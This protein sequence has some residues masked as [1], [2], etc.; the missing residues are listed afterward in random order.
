[1][2]NLGIKNLPN[3]CK[4]LAMPR[5]IS[6]LP[7][8]SAAKF[9]GE[10][11]ACLMKGAPA[12]KV[13]T[14]RSEAAFALQHERRFGETNEAD[15]K[16]RR[17]PEA[18]TRNIEAAALA[19]PQY[20]PL[21]ER[22]ISV[23]LERKQTKPK[24][25]EATDLVSKLNLARPA[26]PR[27]IE[28]RDP[29]LTELAS[30]G[31]EAGLA[32][33]ATKQPA[34][35]Q[36]E[37]ANSGAE[38]HS[39]R[40]S[41]PHESAVSSSGLTKSALQPRKDARILP[42]MRP[43]AE[44]AK[45]PVEV[46]TV[47]RKQ[48][49]STSQP[50]HLAALPTASPLNTVAKQDVP[51]ITPKTPLLARNVSASEIEKPDGNDTR[52]RL[53]G[54]SR[55]SEHEIRSSRS[56]A[57]ASRDEAQA[58]IQIPSR[59][60][61]TPLESLR[62]QRFD[63][64]VPRRETIPIQTP[65]VRAGRSERQGDAIRAQN[66]PP[67]R[68]VQDA[69]NA[70][71]MTDQRTLGKATVSG[72]LQQ[73]GTSS[74]ILS[75][76]RE[77]AIPLLS[78]QDDLVRTR[79]SA[80][81]AG[82]ADL[83]SRAGSQVRGTKGQL[84]V[85]IPR[86]GTRSHEVPVSKSKSDSEEAPIQTYTQTR[87][88]RKTNVSDFAERKL[89][90]HV[91]AKTSS[92]ATSSPAIRTL[93]GDRPA[94]FESPRGQ[95]IEARATEEAKRQ[96]ETALHRINSNSKSLGKYA[97]RLLKDVA[98]GGSETKLQETPVMP[99]Q[100]ISRAM[101]T[102]EVLNNEK[103]KALRPQN[104]RSTH[105][106]RNAASKEAVPESF[107]DRKPLPLTR[108][109]SKAVM[110]EMPNAK[111]S[112]SLERR[113]EPAAAPTLPKRAVEETAP[114]GGM[115]TP[116]QPLSQEDA[117]AETANHPATATKAGNAESFEVDPPILRQSPLFAKAEQLQE[118]R[119]LLQQVLKISQP[120]RL[121]KGSGLRFLWASQEWGPVQFV[122]GQHE[123][124]IVA[125][126]QV[127]DPKV[128]VLLETHR[129]GLQQIFAEQGLRLDR[130]EVDATHEPRLPSIPEVQ[131]EEPRRRQTRQREPVMTTLWNSDE[132]SLTQPVLLEK[133]PTERRLW[134]A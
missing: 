35:K 63:E 26:R 72:R 105:A 67:Q 21:T 82:N 18:V 54:E 113:T 47:S 90:L 110:P 3:P 58:K 85:E 114:T 111:P 57:E 74:A 61:Q 22:T 117:H 87:V 99:E 108:N 59:R 5:A 27:N 127:Q 121:D 65:V 37:A 64:L 112:A 79:S 45:R 50:T 93:T 86:A 104:V 33:P 7:L 51:K 103:G 55:K 62:L 77:A 69:S 49:E 4:A 76:P 133:R 13:K 125:R 1:M 6:V 2:K 11:T 126:V 30:S 123:Q 128:K 43:H 81:S 19:A 32:V 17:L 42:E 12:D 97:E 16:L 31:R 38:L 122:I 95:G 20:T 92:D 36:E 94:A 119:A 96:S 24:R 71:K 80:E 78:R 10:L 44:T 75:P 68:F 124:E 70:M 9:I 120:L 8:R 23:P 106:L 60:G 28:V 132:E 34:P 46:S 98:P 101:P 84:P 129:E 40:S 73:H 66:E 109:L 89:P 100:T 39:I 102:G 15:S 29:G 52:T 131:W 91:T 88:V 14:T 48:I 134:I 116:S 118:L 107:S 56:A 83:T 130:F 53:R 115:A 41:M 25:E